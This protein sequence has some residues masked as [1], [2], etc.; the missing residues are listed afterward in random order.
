[1]ADPFD[2]YLHWLGIRDPERPPNHYRLLGVALFEDD[3]DVLANA[4]DRQMAH[5]R[6][7][8]TGRHSAESQ[9]LLNELAAAKVCLLNPAKKGPYDAALRA[10]QGRGLPTP[11]PVPPPA[12][13][14]AEPR[15]AAEPPAP[16]PI[17][18]GRGSRTSFPTR[19]WPS[20]TTESAAE[21]EGVMLVTPIPSPP[22]LPR[23]VAP[24]PRSSSSTA[25]L[26]ALIGV[27]V[28]LVLGLI[29]LLRNVDALREKL[30]DSL[31]V[32]T[33]GAGD[34]DALARDQGP[35]S[36]PKAKPQAELP[37]K[38]KP[39]A[40][41]P[42]NAKPPAEVKPPAKLEPKPEP[43]PEPKAEPPR[44]KPRED[45]R[46]DVPGEDAQSAALKE[47]REVFKDRYAAAKERDPKRALA[48]FLRQKAADTRDN[49]TAR[50]VLYTEARDTA[51]AAGEARLLP[52]V[53]Q[54]LGRQYRLDWQEMLV[55]T[56]VKAAKRPRD[57]LSNQ[58]LARLALE[59]A[60]GRMARQ[61]YDSAMP[62]GEA[63]REMARKAGDVAT[64]KQA[65]ALLKD[66]AERKQALA[67][68]LDLP[69]EKRSGNDAGDPQ[70][71]WIAARYYC[72]VKDDW[73]RGLGLVVRSGEAALR[74]A[75]QSEL[76]HPLRSP[77]QMVTA[78]DYWYDAAKT[79]DEL[80]RRLA[81]GRAIYWYQRAA[82]D[83]SGLSRTK[84]ERRLAELN[85]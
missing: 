62:L 6:T 59:T 77:A 78:G 69:A 70:S 33:A 44:P 24:S 14:S 22:R 19:P 76:D 23:P 34:E 27:L 52:D 28:L 65:V 66:V 18:P 15:A 45:A 17:E 16:P 79:A 4:A 68:F 36:K 5:V 32:P 64:V 3:P 38:A 40:E 25:M 71:N 74:D 56:L 47:V 82:R 13:P 54:D 8:Q 7:F 35:A 46:L 63:A 48:L 72:L 50:Y 10:G 30:T 29:Y 12:P 37:A 57:S 53:V 55:D 43:K 51:V 75:A 31:G 21:P 2:P 81:R 83:L 39:P 9:K 49:P 41:L 1:M 60:R 73:P 20:E 61:D 26:L 85:K 58:A 80:G 11:P 42:L 67:A 84:V